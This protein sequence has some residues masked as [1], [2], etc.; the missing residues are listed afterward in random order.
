MGRSRLAA[1]SGS[2]GLPCLA[3]YPIAL[4]LSQGGH[5]PPQVLAQL[6]CRFC[7]SWRMHA[8]S[9]A[10]RLTPHSALPV[11]TKRLYP[12]M[13]QRC[14]QLT[15]RFAGSSRGVEARAA[16]GQ[17]RLAWGGPDQ[18]HPQQEPAAVQQAEPD[19][20]DQCGRGAAPQWQPWG[21]WQRAALH[22][23]DCRCGECC[24]GLVEL[25]G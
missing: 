20:A 11:C 22:S 7:L 6:A 3:S 9:G 16:A 1:A 17:H 12:A 13:L 25:A 23:R 18:G 8:C 4:P 14:D 19:D 10:K 15:V 24:E 2:A 21:S 5:L